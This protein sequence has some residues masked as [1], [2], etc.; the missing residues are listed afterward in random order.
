MSRGGVK[1]KNPTWKCN[2]QVSLLQ[3]EVP[4]WKEFFSNYLRSW[5]TFFLPSAPTSGRN[6]DK[7]PF[8]VGVQEMRFARR[9]EISL[10]FGR[11]IRARSLVCLIETLARSDGGAGLWVFRSSGGDLVVDFGRK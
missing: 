7:Y 10:F 11:E 3:Q 4:L 1:D 9:R 2:L 8:L 5:N 6:G